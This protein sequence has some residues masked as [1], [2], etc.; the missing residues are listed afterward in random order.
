ML[1]ALVQ[2]KA[3]ILCDAKLVFAHVFVVGVLNAGELLLVVA[4]PRITPL[5]LSALST[6]SRY[7]LIARVGHNPECKHLLYSIRL[8]HELLVV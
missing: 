2:H 8:E 1:Q 7:H 6:F 5:V 3:T 4:F